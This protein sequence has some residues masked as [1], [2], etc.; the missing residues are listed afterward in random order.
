M[1]HTASRNRWGARVLPAGSLGWAPGGRRGCAGGPRALSLLSPLRAAVTEWCRMLQPC[2][3]AGNG[4]PLSPRHPFGQFWGRA[5]AHLGRELAPQPLGKG[6]GTEESCGER[7]EMC[8][9][10]AAALHP[11]GSAVPG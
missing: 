4:A 5:R 8:L 10:G 1:L 11:N 2:P 9:A 3:G 6:A 7:A